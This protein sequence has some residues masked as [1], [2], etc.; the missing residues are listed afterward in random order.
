MLNP[1]H[2]GG[3]FMRLSFGLGRVNTHMDDLPST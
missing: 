3:G 2:G 1:D